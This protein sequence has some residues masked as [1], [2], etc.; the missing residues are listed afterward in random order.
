MGMELELCCET[1]DFVQFGHGHETLVVAAALGR[2]DVLSDLMKVTGHSVNIAR[3]CSIC[4]L[5]SPF[6]HLE[7]PARDGRTRCK[8]QRHPQDFGHY[9][10]RAIPV[11]FAAATTSCVVTTEAL[12]RWG[13]DLDACVDS[14]R[15]LDSSRSA[16]PGVIVRS[17][18]RV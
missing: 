10:P 6:H 15:L 5:C 16:D 7:E 13:G 8:W 4:V 12:L 11:L 3:P 14:V 17:F 9:W 18:Y 2:L 1:G